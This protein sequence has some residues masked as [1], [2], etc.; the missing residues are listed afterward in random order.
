M[1]MYAY[2]YRCHI[3]GANVKRFFDWSV[4]NKLYILITKT[5]YDFKSRNRQ[6]YFG[7]FKIEIQWKLSIRIILTSEMF[8]HSLWLDDLCNLQLHM[9]AFS[10]QIS[11]PITGQKIRNSSIQSFDHWALDGSDVHGNMAAE[12]RHFNWPMSYPEIF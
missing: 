2:S 8:V 12:L 1:C 5:I 10:L 11:T 4:I 7:V 3:S 9:L 6:D